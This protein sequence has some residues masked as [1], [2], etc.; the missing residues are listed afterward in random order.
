MG[1]LAA[2]SIL[3]GATRVRPWLDARLASETPPT[4]LD[5][6]VDQWQSTMFTWVIVLLAGVLLFVSA[7]IA[8]DAAG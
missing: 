5:Q 1:L 3:Y 6:Q 2:V 4:D 7:S 8:L